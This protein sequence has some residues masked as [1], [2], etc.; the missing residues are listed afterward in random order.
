MFIN[1]FSQNMARYSLSVLEMPLN[2]N[3]PSVKIKQDTI[4]STVT[5]TDFSSFSLL[6]T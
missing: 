6:K 2:P 3:Q 5:L 4:F 1:I